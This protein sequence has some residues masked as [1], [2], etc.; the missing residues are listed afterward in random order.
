MKR[1][2]RNALLACLCA[3][4]AVSFLVQAEDRLLQDAQQYFDKGELNAA[5]IQLKNALQRDPDLAPARLLL[6][7]SYLQQG[8]AASAEKELERARALGVKD[9]AVLPLLGRTWLLQGKTERVLDEIDGEGLSG[10]ALADHLYLRGQAFTLRGDADQAEAHFAKALGAYPE[11]ADSLVGQARLLLARGDREGAGERLA[12]A[13]ELRA[14]HADAWVLD[15]ELQRQAGRLEAAEDRYNRALA[16]QPEHLGA[17][18]GRATVYIAQGKHELAARDIQ[19]VQRR[20]PRHPLAHYLQGLVAFQQGDIDEAAIA[21]EQTLAVLPGHSGSLLLMGTIRYQQG[22]YNQ[23]AHHL[24]PFVTAHPGHVPSAKLLAAA[25]LRTQQSEAAIE[26]LEATSAQAPGDAQLLAMLGSLYLE[27]GDSARGLDLLRQAV[28]LAPD[29]AAIQT[30]LGVGLMLAGDARQA[31]DELEAAVSLGQGLFQADVLLVVT[32][33]NNQEPDKALE[34]ARALQAKLPEDPIPH[35]LLGAVHQRKGDP[36][37]AR[38]AFGRALVLRPDFAPAK[39]NLA[40]M[41]M[42]EGQLDQARTRFRAILVDD[43]SNLDAMYGM[44][45][46]AHLQ[47]QGDQVE[48]WL[49]QARRHHPQAIKPSVLLADYYLQTRQPHKALEVARTLNEHQPNQPDALRVLGLAQMATD[50]GAAGLA[51]FKR[52]AE[53]LPA[54]A[55]V[56]YLLGSAALQ[57]QDLKLA[58]GIF[59]KVLELEAHHAGAL[60]NLGSLHLNAGETEAATRYAD[61][62]LEHHAD[63][64]WGHALSADVLASKGEYAAAAIQARDAYGRDPSQLRLLRYHQLLK[65]SGAGEE[66]VDLLESWLQ[67]RPQD[68]AVRLRAAMDLQERGDARAATVHYEQILEQQPGNVIAMNNLAWLYLEEDP[69]RA[70]RHAEQAYQASPERPE[71]LDTYGWVLVRNDQA[72]K[73]LTY[74]QEALLKAPH[75]AQI[76]YHTAVALHRAGRDREARRE[77]EQALRNPEF[78]GRDAARALHES[79]K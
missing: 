75:L 49:E 15:G 53:R 10:E 14:D 74:L 23:A 21:L 1:W 19:Q 57:Q 59:R 13:L 26:L 46:L 6:G 7:R 20:F 8:E 77:L 48:H 28:Q 62:L 43:P 63:Q 69:G 34:A 56:Q 17:Y 27:H 39:L 35:N 31:T 65:Q 52:L 51:T 37:A 44:V 2:I 47:G 78:E 5:I 4:M 33:L 68:G 30:Q 54:N 3:S 16:S 71:V 11:H 60:F 66:A 29:V 64:P 25:L 73:G 40:R 61:L 38:K 22:Q 12:R 36:E 67:Q 50:S 42:A 55:Q 9:D 32:H 72:E 41:D 58:R 18:L 76:R 45:D 79:L 24:R 70:L